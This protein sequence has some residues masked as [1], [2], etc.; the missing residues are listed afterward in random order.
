MATVCETDPGPGLPSR[1]MDWLPFSA[2]KYPVFTRST[3]TSPTVQFVMPLGSDF[4]PLP[5]PKK[6]VKEFEGTVGVSKLPFCIRLVGV[7]PA[8]APVAPWII[9]SIVPATPSARSAPAAAPPRQLLTCSTLGIASQ[10]KSNATG[11]LD[12]VVPF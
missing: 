9:G 4:D 11:V 6:V 12:P 8:L 10:E 3:L 1:S 5:A 2:W 7:A